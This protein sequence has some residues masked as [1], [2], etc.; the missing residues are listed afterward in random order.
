MS[1]SSYNAVHRTWDH[2]GNL[3]PNFEHSEGARPHIHGA[4]APWLPVGY[5]DK[6]FEVYMTIMAGKLIALT[7]DEWVVPAG[8]ALGFAGVGTVLTYTAN[9]VT[10]RVVDL[11]TGVA[12]TAAKTYTAAALTTALRSRGLIAAA[13]TAV[14]YIS[15]P[16]GVAAQAMYSWAFTVTGEDLSRSNFAIS[17]K[18]HNFYMQSKVAVLCDYALRLPHVPIIASAE[19]LGAVDA[20]GPGVFGSGT[21][22]SQGVTAA[23]VRYSTLTNTDYLAYFAN[24][25]P[26]AADVEQTP[27]AASS[28]TL[29][30]RE[31]SSPEALTTNG[32][33]YVD[34]EVGVFFFYASGGLVAPAGVTGTLTYYH[35][36]AAPAS[37][38]MSDYVSAVGDIK[39]GSFLETD[40]DSNFNLA[41]HTDFRD[42]MGQALTSVR[43]PKD[44][45]DRV[46]TAYEGFGVLDQMP[47]TASAG[48]PDN[49]TYAGASDKE[50]VVNLIS[51]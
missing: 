46:K 11:G 2:V 47:G 8:L 14:D 17:S 7:R 18:F 13:E 29:L 35:Y 49:I 24:N 4:P 21:L 45:L 9:D 27:L 36:A 42:I 28:A 34:K 43:H 33:Y 1:L 41:T 10:E 3:V 30:V 15:K 6:H 37:A 5:Y 23:L 16:I 31:R 38:S 44:Y 19:A 40:A 12:V 39:P 25:Y 50:I 48:I 32:D 20:V 26:V 51:R 22:H